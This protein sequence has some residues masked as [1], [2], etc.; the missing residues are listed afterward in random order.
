MADVRIKRLPFTWR[1]E[2]LVWSGDDLVDWV[3]GGRRWLSDG[4]QDGPAMLYGYVFDRAL[5]SSSGLYAAIFCERGTKGLILREG[6]ILR[7]IDRSYYQADAFAYPVALG[8]LPDG[9]EVIAHCPD[10]Y[11]VIEIETLDDG[12][13][14][15]RREGKAQDFFHSRLSFS[16]DGRFLLSAG[17]VWQPWNGFCLFDV[18]RALRDPR[19][20]DRMERPFGDVTGS[21]NEGE[22][23]AACWLNSSQLL[24]TT[25]PD[26]EY[27]DE[28]EHKGPPCSGVRDVGA[29]E[30]LS[31]SSAWNTG[32]S[33][34]PCAGGVLYVENGHP[35]WWAPGR[36][37]PL[38][39]PDI[40]VRAAPGAAERRG[41][42]HDCPLLAAHPTKPRFAAVTDDEIVVVDLN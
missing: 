33:L 17:W 10:Q 7:E 5:M 30:W 6:E 41:I 13:R 4:N 32:A 31:R 24:V 40:S 27:L 37:A 12:E 15:T 42:V 1:P 3:A 35:H 26:G 39:W 38:V 23:G 22:V 18:E 19:S 21:P 36:D 28:P 20:L 8:R 11:N 16:P 34:S 29:G 9:R 14:L 2:S 25:D